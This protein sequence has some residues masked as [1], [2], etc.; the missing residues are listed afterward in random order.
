MGSN[1]TK[2]N[3]FLFF[4]LFIQKDPGSN[5]IKSIYFYFFIYL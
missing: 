1:P 5:A 4:H 3:L 2:A